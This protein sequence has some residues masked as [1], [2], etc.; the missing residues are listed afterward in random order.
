ME[1]A[2]LPLRREALAG[3]SPRPTVGDE[4]AEVIGSATGGR[5]SPLGWESAV[6]MVKKGAFFMNIGLVV[7]VCLG[8]G[9]LVVALAVYLTRAT[10][11]NPLLK[12]GRSATPLNPPLKGGQS[13]ECDLTGARRPTMRVRVSRKWPVLHVYPPNKATADRLVAFGPV[14][15]RLSG[16][17]TPDE[18]AAADLR[19]VY[20]LSVTILAHNAEG[21]SQTQI[22]SMLDREQAIVFLSEY[23]TWLT[24]L[25]ESKN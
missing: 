16:C 24:D 1:I 10:P 17:F 22:E 15:D 8:F 7:L 21:F 6:R 12:G 18:K 2:S 14:I 25:L 9:G 13:V 5:L 4:S 20:S 19:E 23:L 3:A 11:L